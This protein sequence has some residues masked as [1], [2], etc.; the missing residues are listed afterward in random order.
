MTTISRYQYRGV[1]F[2]GHHTS[3]F[4]LKETTDDVI[5]MP[6]KTKLTYAPI[7]SNQVVDL[8]NLYGPTFGERTFTKNFMFDENM[9]TAETQYQMWT[10]LVNWLMQPPGK[11]PLWDD[12]MHD[13]HY[14]GEVQAAPNFKEDYHQGTLQ[15]TW[16][17]YPFRIK[18][19]A[20]FDDVWDTFNFE[21]DVAQ[22]THLNSERMMTT[23]FNTGVADVAI[24]ATSDVAVT[25][26]INGDVH[27]LV[28]GS[29]NDTKLVLSPGENDVSINS[30]ANVDIS[31]HQEVI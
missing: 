5:G 4:G 23:L 12:V 20:E 27:E 8:S 17:C 28:K 25:L 24:L 14:L 18:D 9:W 6:A 26:V 29:N 2:N 3:E 13:Y 11:I 15:V 7:A 10:K 31:W 30:A 1:T 21:N 22:V 16:Q 19:K